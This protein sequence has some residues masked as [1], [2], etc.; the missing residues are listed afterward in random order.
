MI[1]GQK[2]LI[3][4]GGGSIG[5][6]LVRDF[7][8]RDPEVVRIFDNDEGRLADFK[9][10]QDD[11]RC[12][13]LVGDVRDRQRLERALEDI[14]VVVHLAAMKHVGTSEYNPFEAVKTNVIGVQNLIDAAIDANVDTVVF[15]SSDKAVNP[16]NTMGTTKLLGEKLMTAGNKHK[17][18]PGIRFASVRFG[19]VVGSSQSVIPVFEGQIQQGGPVTLTDPKMTRFVLTFDDVCELIVDALEHT[20]G[21]EVFLRKMDA[22][23]ISDLAEVMIE[24][25]APEYGHEPTDI[26]VV[27]TGKRVAETYHEHVLTEREAARTVENGPLCAILPETGEN[28]YLE[29]DGLDGFR[30]AEDVVRSSADAET[31]SKG[32]IRAL[33]DGAT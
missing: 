28:G 24:T 29:H 8:G 3:T 4:G 7:L 30:P 18:R 5:R 26:D 16:A 11:R 27:T 1:A 10:S 14:D 21:G 9:R 17:G 31:L 25:V 22:V 6:V 32:E 13:Y 2:V 20:S 12:R 33:L 23:Q 15:S 19:N